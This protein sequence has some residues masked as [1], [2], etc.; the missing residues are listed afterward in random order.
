LDG[1]QQRR[2]AY[3]HR[4]ERRT[5]RK[6]VQLRGRPNP[7]TSARTATVT[8]G[9]QSISITQA[10]ADPQWRPVALTAD[11][12]EL[13]TWNYQGVMHGYVKLTFPSSGYRVADWGQ[14]I[15]SGKDT[16]FDVRVERTVGQTLPVATTTAQIY[17]LFSSPYAPGDYTFT[18]KSSGTVR[19][20]PFTITNQA[21]SP[22]IM[23]DARQFTRQH[24]IDFLSREPDAPGLDFWTNE[25]TACGADA[26]CIDRKRVN[27]SGAFFLSQEFR[28][29]GY[30]VYRMYRGGLGRLPYYAEFMPDTGKV[31]AG[32]VVDNRLSPDAINR[33]KEAFAREFVSR[34]E[35]RNIYESLT[36]E[37]Y[38]DRLAQTTGIALTGDERGALIAELAGGA[39]TRDERRA[40]VLGRIVDGVRAVPPATGGVGVDQ[41]FET[42][43]GQ[44]FYDKQFNPAFVQMQYFGYL[45]RDPDQAGF[46]FWLAKLNRFGNFTDAEMVRSFILAPEY[47]ARFGQP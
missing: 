10:A 40:R 25:V 28:G 44:E 27:T 7:N 37:G 41:I 15:G 6:Y 33:N 2:L 1:N 23:D 12:V 26:G 29:T 45:R 24:Y 11:Q 46:D 17:R 9:G 14:L 19:S 21:V 18:I 22:N 34:A 13:K 3:G 5:R 30:F 31:A 20:L 36:D 4:V 38:V 8:V 42:R 47:R 39:G 43:Y 32:I 35:F 16:S